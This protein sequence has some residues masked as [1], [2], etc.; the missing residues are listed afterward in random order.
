LA[1]ALAALVLTVGLGGAPASARYMTGLALVDW[2]KADGSTFCPGYIAGM[3]DYQSAL[4]TLDT[5]TPRFCL[6]SNVKLAELRSVVLGQLGAKS[7]NELS[8]VAANL[9]VPALAQ[10]F[11]TLPG[12]RG[13]AERAAA[14][15]T[16]YELIDWCADDTS[17]FCA[18]YIA[19][20]VDYQDLL[21]SAGTWTP[22]FCLAENAQLSALEQLALLRL[23]AN[24]PSELRK[25]A[26]SL[27]V[28][29][30]F[31]QFP[32]P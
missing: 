4:Q 27:V 10:R 1:C 28:P 32:C 14:Y 2:C 29:A 5:D 12:T 18:G 17:R 3:V 23:R 22:R 9:M 30:F 16:G 25:L 6:P 8:A 13:C 15:V 19:A 31:R 7:P 24:P 21:Q 26:A 11:P 20:L